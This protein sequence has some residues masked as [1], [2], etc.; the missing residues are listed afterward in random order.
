MLRLQE[1]LYK[2]QGFVPISL[3]FASSNPLLLCTTVSQAASFQQCSG[4]DFEPQNPCA[5]STSAGSWPLGIFIA[6]EQ[7]MQRLNN[8]YQNWKRNFKVLG[9]KVNQYTSTND[10]KT[11]D[12]KDSKREPVSL[13]LVY[14]S[15]KTVDDYFLRSVLTR[16]LQGSRNKQEIKH[17][18][19]LRGNGL[20]SSDPKGVFF[21][22]TVVHA[23]YH[24]K[25]VRN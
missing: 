17:Q 3:A 2:I 9:Y 25:P 16:K 13:H 15:A 11:C 14:A 7:R 23:L 4:V 10:P 20:M 18:I 1:T 19:H 5:A 21:N 8:A 12:N 6:H 22:I 24:K